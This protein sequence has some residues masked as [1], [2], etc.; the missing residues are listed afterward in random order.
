MVTLDVERAR[1]AFVAIQCTAGNAG[2]F[3]IADHRFAVGNE[4]EHSAYQC[5]VECI[6]LAGFFSY[7]FAGRDEA[8]NSAHLVECRLHAFAVCN[9]HFITATQ[10]DAAVAAFRNA[11]FDMQLEVTELLICN[12]VRA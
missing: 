6:P 3:L 8:V 5:D 9:L 7:H 12:Q 2:D 10:V 11:E 1:L 4:C